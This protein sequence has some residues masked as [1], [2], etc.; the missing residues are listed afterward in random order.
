MKLTKR[1]AIVYNEPQPSRYDATG[2][3]RA[4]LEVLD[5]VAAVCDALQGLGYDVLTVPL[6][7]LDA[8]AATLT[9]LDIDLVFNLF[10]GF[11]GQPETE[12][13]VPEILEYNGIPYTGCNAPA[14]RLALDKAAAKRALEAAGI[15]TPAFQLLTPDTI[16]DFGLGYPCIVKPLREDA[17]HGLSADSVVKDMTGLSQQLYK[18]Y[19]TYGDAAL[20]EEYIGGREL[21]AT[22]LRNGAS[23][24]LPVSEIIY[25]L[26]VGLPEILTFAAKW[27]PESPYYR[28]TQPV[29]PA[30]LSSIT[31][32]EATNTALRA[33]E[34]LGD[35]QG[36]ARV[37]MRL[38]TSGRCHVLEINPNPD[39]TPG[40]GAVLQAAAAGMDYPRFLTKIMT[41]ALER[42]EA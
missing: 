34:L 29:C 33:F 38:D 23:A 37:D 1:I 27:Q 15:P 26:P 40:S 18:V 22:V 13:L 28:G 6:A 31:R 41:A 30:E 14:L 19:R 12:S 11:C 35:G 20:V 10:E 4:A 17:S 7:S 8:L 16:S 9:S 39:I 24:V 42:S 3:A 2:E 5:T 21:N 32:Q 25:D 36:Y